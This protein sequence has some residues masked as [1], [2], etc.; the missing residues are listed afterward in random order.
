MNRFKS[1]IKNFKDDAFAECLNSLT[2]QFVKMTIVTAIT[3]FVLGFIFP[4]RETNE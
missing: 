4:D 2:K 1:G 3:F